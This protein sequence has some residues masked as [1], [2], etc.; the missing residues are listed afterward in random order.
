MP[1]STALDVLA[2]SSALFAERGYY[3]VGM[4][5][6]AAAAGLSRA[7]LYRHYGTKDKILSEL[8]RRAVAEIEVQAAAL[9]RLAA[10]DLDEWMLGYVR[11]HR[12]RHRRWS[13][14]PC[15]HRT[16]RNGP[17]ARGDGRARG[18]RNS[19]GGARSNER[20]DRP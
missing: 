18:G 11:F 6:L 4:E 3:A 5:E 19:R 12:G 14:P 9:P 20:A 2:V 10:D 8:T 1:S 13:G 17:P 16:S 7:T 15:S